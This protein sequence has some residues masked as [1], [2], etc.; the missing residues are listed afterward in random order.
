MKSHEK[1]NRPVSIAYVPKKTYNRW[2]Q[3]YKRHFSYD[4]IPSARMERKEWTLGKCRQTIVIRGFSFSI[5]RSIS[6]RLRKVKILTITKPLMKLEHRIS[7]T[8]REKPHNQIV[9]IYCGLSIP[10]Y[11][12]IDADKYWTAILRIV[13]YSKTRRAAPIRNIGITHRGSQLF[14]EFPVTFCER[15]NLFCVRFADYCRGVITVV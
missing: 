9:S 7:V 3:E 1:K 4:W 14:C 11:M 6:Y 10:F 12:H 13:V 8:A 5:I 15:D 2:K